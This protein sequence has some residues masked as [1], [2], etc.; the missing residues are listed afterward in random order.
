MCGEK[1]TVRWRLGLSHATK[2]PRCAVI[3]PETFWHCPH[4]ARQDQ[5]LHPFL[6]RAIKAR[7]SAADV[8]IVDK[9]CHERL[10]DKIVDTERGRNIARVRSIM[11]LCIRQSIEVLGVQLLMPFIL[12]AQ[13]TNKQIDTHGN[14]IVNILLPQVLS[15]TTGSIS[16]IP[17]QVLETNHSFLAV[18]LFQRQTGLS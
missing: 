8:V 11:A 17:T 4:V 10:K 3:V 6:C 9:I 16:M 14:T 15:F 18:L 2:M 7:A 1:W 13:S 5:P 12:I